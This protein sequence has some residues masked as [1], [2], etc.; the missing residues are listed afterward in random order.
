[1]DKIKT[2]GGR[3]F[4]TDALV[5]TSTPIPYDPSAMPGAMVLGVDDNVYVSALN[6]PLNTY[7]WKTLLA[8]TADGTVAFNVTS[9][10]TENTG[11]GLLMGGTE[12]VPGDTP[13][14]LRPPRINL[15]PG[16]EPGAS[17]SGEDLIGRIEFMSRAALTETGS[18]IRPARITV[19]AEAPGWTSTSRPCN[20]N[21]LVAPQGSPPGG[22]IPRRFAIYSDGSTAINSS[23]G[24]SGRQLTVTPTGQ[25]QIGNTTG[26]EKLSV[27]G[28]IQ[29]TSTSGSFMVGAL[30]V[31]GSRKTGW[32]AA[33]G[34]ATRTTFVTST[35]TTEQLAQRLKAL[36]DDLISHGLIGA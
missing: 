19:N 14:D 23:L 24:A 18:M 29:V 31:V 1:M 5:A 36:I 7:I 16:I 26:T 34:T 12:P 15:M 21:I 17:F 4:R 30:S 9:L 25:V 33:T 28:N 3:R 8:Q 35:V 6:I 10:R 27:T 13:T 32:A 11:L 2:A 20:F 22:V